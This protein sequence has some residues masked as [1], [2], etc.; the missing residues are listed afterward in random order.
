M[1]LMDFLMKYTFLFIV[2]LLAFILVFIIQRYKILKS[3]YAD[4]ENHLNNLLLH[5]DNILAIT[6]CDGV[7]QAITPTFNKLF[8]GHLEYEKTNEKISEI[9]L[10]KSNF[11]WENI[12]QYLA[13]EKKPIENLELTVYT[14]DLNYKMILS[15]FPVFKRN[16]KI[17]GYV[18]IFDKGDYV[19]NSLHDFGHIEKLTNIG[20]IAAGMAH[21]L[22]TPLGS[23][24][25]SADYIKQ[26][27][28]EHSIIDEVSKI[29]NRA[30]HCSKVVKEL[31]GYVRKTE[32]I[33]SIY[34]IEDIIIKVQRMIASEINK[35][36]IHINISSSINESL[37]KCNENQIEQLFFNLF[38]NACYAL[39]KEGEINI[40]ITDESIMNQIVI[41]FS[42]NGLG[43]KE[44]HID[45]VFDPFYTTKPGSEGTGLGL[46]L[47][48]KI[49]LE[50]GGSIDVNSIEGI[51]TTFKLRFPKVK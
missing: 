45:K 40:K 50:H 30:E 23:I 18:H 13:E 39:D 16:H 37:I 42:D 33:K 4:K 29:K 28:T 20:K 7:L 1:E 26:S 48:N 5:L 22:N 41:E 3:K 32:E 10:I 35:K 27:I 46:A 51:G 21:E 34:N 6:D 12:F 9:V 47:C 31:L 19:K 36:N 24:M 17:Q 43:I 38:S 8:L 25:L 14:N 44:E 2:I 11:N 15:V 49:M